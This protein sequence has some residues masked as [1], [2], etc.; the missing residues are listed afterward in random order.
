MTGP[1][2]KIR[3]V[4]GSMPTRC[5]MDVTNA[6]S[7]ERPRVR[8]R[9][10]CEEDESESENP[11]DDVDR[12]LVAAYEHEEV[13]SPEPAY[14][15]TP[16]EEAADG[17]DDVQEEEEEEEEETPFVAAEEAGE[18]LLQ[19]HPRIL[20]RHAS[21]ICRLVKGVDLS[22]TKVPKLAE[23]AKSVIE[24]PRVAN[25]YTVMTETYAHSR[26]STCRGRLYAG[27]LSLQ[28]MP[29]GLRAALTKGA[30]VDVDIV[31]ANPCLLLGFI[32]ET[33]HE[34]PPPDAPEL[35]RYVRGRM[36]WLSCIVPG[37]EVPKEVAKEVVNRMICLPGNC[38]DYWQVSVWLREHGLTEQGLTLADVDRRVFRMQEDLA[39]FYAWFRDYYVDFIWPML[40]SEPLHARPRPVASA[41]TLF[42]QRIERSATEAARCEAASQGAEIGA[43][44]H[45]GFLAAWDRPQKGKRKNPNKSPTKA[46]LEAM[47]LA[48][49]ERDFCAHVT[50]AEKKIESESIGKVLEKLGVDATKRAPGALDFG[51]DPMK[52]QDDKAVASALVKAKGHEMAFVGD[53][54]EFHLF[55]YEDS[56]CD[57]KMIGLWK[58]RHAHGPPHTYTEFIDGLEETRYAKSAHWWRQVYKSLQGRNDLYVSWKFNED[59][60]DGCFPASNGMVDLHKAP[61]I[62]DLDVTTCVT[63]LMPKHH[64]TWKWDLPIDTFVPDPEAYA[65]FTATW[66]KFFGHDPQFMTAF[67]QRLARD[68]MTR[69]NRDK[70]I[71]F[72][73]GPGNNGKTALMR[74]VNT[75]YGNIIIFKASPDLL[76]TPLTGKPNSEL[77]KVRR[78]RIAL[79]EEPPKDT[80]CMDTIKDLTGGAQIST[81]D[82][83]ASTTMTKME[84]SIYACANTT[85]E[86]EG[87][88]DAAID[89][90][91]LVNLPC[92]FF[93]NREAYEEHVNGPQGT[94]DPE[95]L[96]RLHIGNEDIVK[97]FEES[98]DLRLA[99]FIYLSRAYVQQ[100]QNGGPPPIPDL[101]LDK[102]TL[103]IAKARSPINVIRDFCKAT[104]N[105]EDYLSWD[106]LVKVYRANG[107]PR[108]RPNDVRQAIDAWAAVCDK[109]WAGRAPSRVMPRTSGI[110]GA[111]LN[112][113]YAAEMP[114]W[115]GDTSV[116]A[117]SSY[118]NQS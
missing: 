90:F 73:M 102:M 57:A 23:W 101:Y 40:S 87:H 81:R 39:R 1:P 45:D 28:K 38:G 78:A 72:L 106:D 18:A 109:V 43:I 111:R 96:A 54:P 30:Y 17:D 94:R 83:F 105:K 27:D 113:Q 66:E 15:D 31:N 76:T 26:T 32:E 61:C 20:T 97:E 112:D 5:L 117:N 114:V 47:T 79:V 8:R 65:R 11:W 19:L 84:A 80:L 60:N 88:D 100:R 33:G 12:M 10:I 51:E 98:D 55:M 63:K 50:F 13:C 3:R 104:G 46:Q 4:I 37:H 34:P 29:R 35:R 86:L 21:E 69:G 7:L 58:N 36:E 91:M 103:A 25:G 99:G 110:R 82:L 16:R 75:I 107:L 95:K 52:Y 93:K 67:T 85:P 77:D 53:K 59:I 42:L 70:K 74:I 108:V 64:L 24:M 6:E 9:V 22:E 115:D 62:E 68:L 44:I 14:V 56:G 71:V 116:V 118:L 89:R 49:R 92:T 48:A 41:I 2:A